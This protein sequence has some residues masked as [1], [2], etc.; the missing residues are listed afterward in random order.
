MENRAGICCVPL[1]EFLN[2]IKA[3]SVYQLL[4]MMMGNG[5]ESMVDEICMAT[6][7]RCTERYI[8]PCDTLVLPLMSKTIR[9]CSTTIVRPHPQT[10]EPNYSIM[11]NFANAPNNP[12][13]IKIPISCTQWS[14]FC[15]SLQYLTA[16]NIG[17]FPITY[18]CTG[19]ASKASIPQWVLAC[20][21]KIVEASSKDQQI[22]ANIK[23][24]LVSP[25]CFVEPMQMHDS[26]SK[27]D[28]LFYT[29][30]I[31]LIEL[32]AHLVCLDV[33]LVLCAKMCP[34]FVQFVERVGLSSLKRGMALAV[35]DLEKVARRRVDFS[36][37]PTTSDVI[38]MIYHQTVQG[39]RVEFSPYDLVAQGQVASMTLNVRT[40]FERWLEKTMKSSAG[41]TFCSLMP[42]DAGRVMYNFKRIS[43]EG[44]KLNRLMGW[45]R[46]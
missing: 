7:S 21:N 33:F 24:M 36:A 16:S 22:E 6:L 43:I 28:H 5:N 10:M 32:H 37:C 44:R 3:G 17:A 4:G 41:E 12:Q 15:T 45:N 25:E 30:K 23:T 42:D 29:K 18:S 31:N 20:C 34:E 14:E 39:L 19:G 8:V 11:V 13:R 40:E 35:L 26:R 2:R 1:K 46:Q 38:N 9:D 27:L